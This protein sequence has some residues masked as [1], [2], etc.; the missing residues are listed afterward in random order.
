MV[1]IDVNGQSNVNG[2]K[3]LDGR[4]NLQGVKTA[5]GD[6]PSHPLMHGVQLRERH[7]VPRLVNV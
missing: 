1:I 7:A 3:T 6:H 2:K 4:V 5:L